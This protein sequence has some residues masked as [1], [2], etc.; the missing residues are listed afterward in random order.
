VRDGQI[1]G[2]VR[3]AANGTLDNPG[4]LQPGSESGPIGEVASDRPYL[5]YGTKFWGGSVIRNAIPDTVEAPTHYERLGLNGDLEYAVWNGEPSNMYNARSLTV[6][7]P[8]LVTLSP[9]SV[10][11][12]NYLAS[13]LRPMGV[14]LRIVRGRDDVAL[15]RSGNSYDPDVITEVVDGVR[16]EVPRDRRYNIISEQT[17][18][19]MGD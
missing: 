19:G 15:L 11:R 10:R 9:R 5:S 7:T 8:E 4:I 16:H 17:Y 6:Y 12:L 1:P 13:I 14:V 2:Q 18:T 3:R